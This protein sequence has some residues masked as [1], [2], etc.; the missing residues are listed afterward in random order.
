[1]FK[2][3]TMVA[4]LAGL[5]G[6]SLTTSAIAAD[7]PVRVAGRL[8]KIEGKTLT[9]TTAADKATQDTVITCN[10]ATKFRRDGDQSAVAFTDL[11]VGQLVRAYYSKADKIAAAVIIAKPTP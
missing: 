3:M 7:P 4:L 8:S 9:I 2:R 10:D 6:F 5:V 11:K 1:M